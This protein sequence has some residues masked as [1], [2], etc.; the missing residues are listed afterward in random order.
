MFVEFSSFVVSFMYTTFFPFA[1]NITLSTDD[2]TAWRKREPRGERD[3][4]K[5]LTVKEKQL[6]TE[7]Y[8][9]KRKRGSEDSEIDG[10]PHFHI[11][12]SSKISK[13]SEFDPL[14][15]KNPQ[16]FSAKKKVNFE[17]L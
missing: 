6:T 9:R 16:I 1:Y 15:A 3:S 10:T 7:R 5:A 4:K 8:S 12:L 2:Q 13:N 14:L 11:N 17:P